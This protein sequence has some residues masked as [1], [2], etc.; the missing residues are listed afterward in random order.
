[1]DQKYYISF[2]NCARCNENH[3]DVYVKTLPF[4]VTSDAGDRFEYYAICPTNNEI[5]FVQFIKDEKS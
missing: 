3:T 4:P 2:D 5:V 1:M